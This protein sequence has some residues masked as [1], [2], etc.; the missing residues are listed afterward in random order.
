[1]KKCT[2]QISASYKVIIQYFSECS[3]N[4]K[5][6][7]YLECN[8]NDIVLRSY[9]IHIGYEKMQKKKNLQKQARGGETVL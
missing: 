5:T 2:K 6:G 1:M 4:R 8:E 7:N 9:I 3:A